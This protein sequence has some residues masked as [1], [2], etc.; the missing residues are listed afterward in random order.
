MKR[1]WML[2]LIV[3]GFVFAKEPAMQ[4]IPASLFFVANEGQWEEPFAFKAS[5]GNV[6]YYVTPQGMTLDIWQYERSH[7]ARDP[8]DRFDPRH[9]PEPV[10]VRGH[11]LKID[12]VNANT[13]PQII[14]EDKLASYSNY[15]L[16]RDSCKW[17]SF[18]GHYQT[19]RMKDIWPGVDVVQKIQAEGVETL[20]RV[21]AGA[22]AQQISV[23]IEGL[24]APL[25]TDRQGN[26]ILSTSLGEI[27]EK[28]PFAYQVINHR[29]VEVPVRFQVLSNNQYGLSFEAFDTSHELVIDPLVYSTFLGGP[30]TDLSYVYG[31]TEDRDGN[32]IAVGK[33][34]SPRFPTTPGS[35]RESPQD[36]GN[37][38]IAKFTPDGRNLIFSTFIA[39]SNRAFVHVNVALVDA[40]N[41]IY[42][43]ATSNV[44]P[45]MPLTTNAFDTTFVGA[46]EAYFAR[47]S[48]LGSTLEF[49]SYLG[50]Q[51]NDF[52]NAMNQDSLGMV[53]LEGWTTSPDFPTTNNALYPQLTG[54]ANCFISVFDPQTATLVYS[55]FFP[56][57]VGIRSSLAIIS[58]MKLW[59]SGQCFG[60]IPLTTDA[61]QSTG[62]NNVVGFISLLDFAN[63]QVLYSTYWGGHDYACV[64]SCTPINGHQLLIAGWTGSSDYPVSSN[65]Y[66]TLP[67]VGLSYKGFITIFDWPQTL[68]HSTYFGSH[69]DNDEM[70]VTKAALC[71]NNSIV[72]CGETWAQDFPTTPDAFDPNFNGFIDGFLA[73]LSPDLARL[74]YST[75]FGGNDRDRPTSFL[76]D[77]SGSYWIAGYTESYN[78]PTTQDAFQRQ[79]TS[80]T[81]GFISHFVVP[82]SSSLTQ[83][84]ILQPIEFGIIA[85]PNPFNSSTVLSIEAPSAEQ[86]TL[87]LFNVMGQRV[88]SQDLGRLNRG[89]HNIPLYMNQFSSGIYYVVLVG[90]SVRTSARLVSLK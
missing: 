81:D 75:F 31:L 36:G 87:Q 21:Q 13:Q 72:F 71:S 29:Q 90:K 6:L 19:V 37:G 7:I 15:F 63:R 12:F 16:G 89:Q 62:G 77:S 22:N 4:H 60:N 74:E 45:A 61:Y 26:L 54:E 56:I 73:R 5:V 30:T 38:F 50:G 20:Y 44:N 66:D 84:R 86:L 28:A 80:G 69:S 59:Y 35:Y 9:E 78:Y 47:L 68:V 43:A 70:Q 24:T 11:V 85:A 51:Q 67:P 53:Y 82:E 76:T 65:A 10:I 58:P 3:S 79:T 1:V 34:E 52:I 48:S 39:G 40:N 25:R 32:K 57:D 8:M 33:T 46:Y 17:R 88:F 55:T 42:F 49:G 41:S 14:G 23:Q 27:I 64:S 83:I 18:V 2:V